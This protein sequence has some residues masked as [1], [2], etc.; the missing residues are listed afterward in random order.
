MSEERTHDGASRQ[1]ANS[2]AVSLIGE[3]DAEAVLEDGLVAVR[4]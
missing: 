3:I 2:H 1:L 4:R